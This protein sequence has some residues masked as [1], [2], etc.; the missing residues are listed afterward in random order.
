[1]VAMSHGQSQDT[2]TGVPERK[3]RLRCVCV[4]AVCTRDGG[5]GDETVYRSGCHAGDWGQGRGSSKCFCWACT[6]MSSGTLVDLGV[7]DA[8]EAWSVTFVNCRVLGR[9]EKTNLCG[10]GSDGVLETTVAIRVW[11]GMPR[12]V[13]STGRGWVTA[14]PVR[15]EK[16]RD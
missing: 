1:M 5:K 9:D 12:V 13:A 10:D 14:S 16:E 11:G 3:A 6:Q 15:R 4:R 8:C 2:R 7:L